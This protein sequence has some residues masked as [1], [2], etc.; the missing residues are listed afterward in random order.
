MSDAPPSGAGRPGRRRRIVIVF[1]GRSAE[2]EISCSTAVG[3]LGA[4]DPHRYAVELVAIT[5]DGRW[6]RA[7]EAEAVLASGGPAALP[8]VLRAEGRA[9]EPGGALARRADDG[10]L[11]PVVLPLL[12]GPFGEDGTV[13]GLLELAGVA[14][15]GSGVLG[16]AVAMDKGVA[17]HLL[18]AAGL[19]LAPWLTLRDGEVDAGLARRVGEELGWPVFV[20]PANLGSSIGV[21]R[22]E[23]P[24]DLEAAVA[25]ALSYD[26]W[27]VVEAAVAGRELECAVL[28][29]RP[30]RASVVGEVRASRAFYD[31]EDKYH[32]GAAQLVVP[33]EIPPSRAEAVRA[34]ALRAYRAVRAEGMARVDVFL[35]PTGRVVVNEVNTIPGFTPISMYPRLWAA[36]GLDY[37][38][39]LDELVALAL[40]RWERRRRRLGRARGPASPAGSA[41]R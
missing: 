17:R 33:A 9:I 32:L 30:P 21:S 27:A 5:R 18:A 2:H 10:E 7:E 40:A 41:D 35:E 22:V 6:V 28:G 31:Y 34:V 25:E 29:D 20:K 37:A 13:Q 1:G 14:Y 3:V 8:P 39:L 19:D 15:V 4:L 38:G 11:A 12:H 16:S 36:S 23:G 24:G 26:E